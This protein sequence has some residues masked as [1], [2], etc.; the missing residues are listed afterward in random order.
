MIR[1]GLDIDGTI[2]ADSP[3]FARIVDAILARNGE[4]HVVSSQSRLG[5]RETVAELRAY[6]VQYTALYLLPEISEAQE[7]CPHLDLNWFEKHQWL[8]VDYAQRH[9]LTHF[10][11]DDPT[12]LT[13]FSR[14][15]P[16]VEA[17]RQHESRSSGVM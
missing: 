1:I 5:E 9:S 10:V 7:F 6:G 13:L 14:F 17:I 4:A 2:T 11:D 12:V 3:G 15:A 8:K 16:H